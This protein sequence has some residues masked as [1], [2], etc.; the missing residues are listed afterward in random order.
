V[1]DDVVAE[2]WNLTLRV[3]IHRTRGRFGSWLLRYW[4]W[5]CSGRCAC[6]GFGHLYRH[7]WGSL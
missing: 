4:G 3:K 5:S 6:E 2:L 1:K 7:R